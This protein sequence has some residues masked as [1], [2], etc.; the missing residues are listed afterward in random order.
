[1]RSPVFWRRS[2][3]AAGVY[4]SALLGFLGT[5]VAARQLGPHD[6]GLLAIVIAVTGFFQLFGDLTVEEALVKFGFRYVQ[7]E[8]WG[9][10]RRLF[11][12]GLELKL[13]GGLLGALL[14]AALAPASQALF[15]TRGLITALLVAALLPLAQSPEGA[16]AA[17]LIVRRRYDVRAGFL[18]VSMLFRT[19]ALVIGSRL[20][21]VETVAAMVVAQAAATAAI[22][23]AGVWLLRR[24][25]QAPVQRL[26]HDRLPFRRFVVQSSVGSVL[27]PMRGLLGTM[28]LGIVTTPVQVGYFRAAQAPQ[29]VFASLSSPARMVL[30]AEQTYEF[31]RGRHERLYRM[32]RRYTLWASAAMLVA[33]PL[34]WWWMPTLIRVLL[35]TKYEP[36]TTAAR[37][38]LFVAA[39]QVVLG[40]TKSFPVSIGRPQ[41]RIVAQSTEI[42]VLVPALLALGAWKGATGGAAAFLIASI[43]FA[44]AWGVLLLRLRRDPPR[45]PAV[46]PVPGAPEL[47]P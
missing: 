4:V 20:G 35:A 45:A 37:L 31:E 27:S 12:V 36:A 39:I 42:A 41:L 16:A 25:P 38:M 5:I 3:T 10:L 46:T 43:A 24:Y 6:F 21:V 28:L 47:V 26:G 19:I 8:D 11:R 33:V 18:V 22:G 14:V 40:W 30:L 13:A 1:M 23:V 44:A 2:A 9:R 32:L 34:L 29:S 17:V 7:N 15:G